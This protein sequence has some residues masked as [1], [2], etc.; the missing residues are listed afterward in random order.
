[1]AVS[2]LEAMACGVPVVMFDCSPG[3][4]EVVTDGKDVVVVAQGLVPG[5]ADGL[6]RLMA[7][8]EL[9]RSMGAAA[10]ETARRYSAVVDDWE[11][12]FAVVER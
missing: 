3:L 4:R 10:R 8:E 12:L 7:D 11:E 2:A 1:L 9:R 6:R 5:L